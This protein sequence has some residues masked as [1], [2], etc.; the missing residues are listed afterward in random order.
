MISTTEQRRDCYFGQVAIRDYGSTEIGAVSEC[1]IG[2]ISTPERRDISN[3]GV[4]E[5]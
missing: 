4:S 1:D 2:G 3:P 5:N